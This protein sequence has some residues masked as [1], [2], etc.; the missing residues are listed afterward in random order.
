MK[1]PVPEKGGQMGKR[2]VPVYQYVFIIQLET[3]GVAKM[4]PGFIFVVEGASIL[5]AKNKVQRSCNF[6]MNRPYH[7][8]IKSNVLFTGD[9]Q[10]D[11]LEHVLQKAME[12]F[13]MAEPRMSVAA[14]RMRVA[15]LRNA[16]FRYEHKFNGLFF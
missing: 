16:S 5:H 3:E 11:T 9:W 2:K 12:I 6:S 1:L 7:Y 8:G 4:P 10:K 13:S 14:I 15:K